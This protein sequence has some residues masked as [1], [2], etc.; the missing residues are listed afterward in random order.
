MPE[1]LR[2]MS[3]SEPAS[4]SYA[5]ESCSSSEYSD[6]QGGST[7]KEEETNKKAPSK[8]YSTTDTQAPRSAVGENVNGGGA[9]AS[10]YMV[11]NMSAM[12]QENLNKK[13]A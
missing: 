3:E 12:S 5:S 8:N 6:E 13:N 10:A 9:D 7:Q 11:T 1:K 2:D 4:G